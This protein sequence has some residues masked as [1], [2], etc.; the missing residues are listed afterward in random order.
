M[1]RFQPSRRC[2]HCGRMVTRK[3]GLYRCEDCRETFGA[4]LEAVALGAPPEDFSA[5]WET[6]TLLDEGD[7]QPVYR[8]IR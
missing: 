2:P 6:V 4:E 8:K 1:P 3:A 7:P 5:G